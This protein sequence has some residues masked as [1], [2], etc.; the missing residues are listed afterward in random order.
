MLQLTSLR[1]V[2]SIPT[3][4]VFSCDR[5]TPL[6]S[7]ALRLWWVSPIFISFPFR[8]VNLT[9]SFYFKLILSSVF[10][11]LTSLRPVVG[12]RHL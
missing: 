4:L 5:A 3:E 10:R 11:L 8:V 12:L 6:V 7:F 9:P 2:V 1:P